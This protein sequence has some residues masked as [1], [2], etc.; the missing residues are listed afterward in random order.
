[1]MPRCMRRPHLMLKLTRHLL[2]LLS[3]RSSKQQQCHLLKMDSP[4]VEG[5]LLTQ[6]MTW[7]MMR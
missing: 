3:W 7:K 5:E 4:V 6:T 1:M 2:R